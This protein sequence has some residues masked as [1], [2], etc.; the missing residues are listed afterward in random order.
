MPSA[1]VDDN[2]MPSE[3]ERSNT[4]PYRFG[5][6]SDVMSRA[7]CQA[8]EDGVGRHREHMAVVSCSVSSRTRMDVCLWRPPI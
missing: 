1:K 2:E 7:F 6:V 8:A 5:M 3:N 4:S